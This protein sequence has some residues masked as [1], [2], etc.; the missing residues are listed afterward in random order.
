[1]PSAHRRTRSLRV[2][3]GTV[4]TLL[5]ALAGC[6]RLHFDGASGDAASDT[7]G[8]PDALPRGFFIAPTGDDSNPGTV[9]APWR[10][11]AAA[12]PKLGPGD[13]LNL[14]DGNYTPQ[15]TGMLHADCAATAPNGT[16]DAPIA[17]VAHHARKAFFFGEVTAVRLRN[18]SHWR[19]EGVY[20][21]GQDAPDIET[22]RAVVE[23][24]NTDHIALR[25]LLLRRPNREFNSNLVMIQGST[26]ILLEDSEGYDF[27]RG[28]WDAYDSRNVT[29][30]RLYANGRGFGDLA[31]SYDSSWP[32]DG[33]FG[34]QSYYSASVTFEDLVFEGVNNAINIETGDAAPIASNGVGDDNL[35]RHVIALASARP[36][37]TPIREGITVISECN[38]CAA[39]DHIAANN[40]I[41]N[42]VLLNFQRGM[43]LIGE[44]TQVAEST[45]VNASQQGVVLRSSPAA[46]T[47]NATAF[48]QRNLIIGTS[49][50]A[51]QVEANIDNWLIADLN[52]FANTSEVSSSDPGK[53][54]RL[55][56]LDPQLGNC[57]RRLPVGSPLRTAANG[58]RIGAEVTQRS[59]AGVDTGT[60]LW[61][62][63]FPCG[64]VVA[65]VNDDA[66]TA[67][68]GAH[69]RMH[70]QCE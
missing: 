11:F 15:T 30:R 23:L 18:C 68:I 7:D 64:A 45:I 10:T 60:P 66:A 27:H 17:I 43:L 57:A 31:G 20:G 12:L 34:A 14:A 42:V 50:P 32:N 59:V 36:G 69:T 19:V 8:D 44:N 3:R 39:P 35:V 51:V 22:G 6:G 62:P 58:S 25:K 54:V 13:Q 63:S 2:A 61:T 1:M 40:R 4:L 52:S 65:G 38:P 67:C 16:R 24:I 5:A 53:T 70:L 21:Q 37:G 56:R 9:D 28:A 48:L 33:D 49:G 41:D 55:Q 46:A 26:D 29:F 47:M